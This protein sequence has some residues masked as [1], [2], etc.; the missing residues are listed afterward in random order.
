MCLPNNTDQIVW[1]EEGEAM[2][3]K[4]RVL[5]LVSALILLSWE[6]GEWFWFYWEKKPY[7]IVHYLYLF[8]QKSFIDLLNFG[9]LVWAVCGG[10]YFLLSDSTE[11]KKT[12][13][14]VA[15]KCLHHLIKQFRVLDGGS[16]NNVHS[17]VSVLGMV[18]KPIICIL[19]VKVSKLFLW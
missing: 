4:C 1:G 14:N 3:F 5:Q 8:V 7:Q 18:Q 11:S 6:W 15:W 13:R 19:F 9:F 16:Q 17:T 12:G 10:D 2:L